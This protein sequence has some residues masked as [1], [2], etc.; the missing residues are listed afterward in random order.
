MAFLAK[1]KESEAL[2]VNTVISEFN[3]S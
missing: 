1:Y 3:F 2:F